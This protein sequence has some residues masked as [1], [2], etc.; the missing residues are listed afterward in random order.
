MRAP[1]HRFSDEVRETTRSIAAEMVREGTVAQ[2]PDQLE[3]WI[4]R[5]P[6]VKQTLEKDGYD[7]AFTAHDLFP[8][9]QAFTGQAASREVPTD[10]PSRFSR[11]AWA[12]G[13]ALLL[14]ILIG[15]LIGMLG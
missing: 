15:L 9:L 1:R 12:A 13:L 2:T 8:L 5:R 7:T 4:S 6:G 14:A 3:E 11:P 10:T